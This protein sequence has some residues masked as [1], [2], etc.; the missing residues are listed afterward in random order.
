MTFPNSPGGRN[1]DSEQIDEDPK[2]HQAKPTV[3]HRLLT[4]A[5]RGIGDSISLIG[6]IS[7]YILPSMVIMQIL[8][9]TGIIACI[10]RW[11]YPSMRLFGLPGEASLALFTGYMISP[12]SGLTILVT[13]SPSVRELTILGTML[14]ICH[15]AILEGPIAYRAGV[16]LGTF[17]ASRLVGSLA[18]GFVLNLVLL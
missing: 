4:S 14:A 13:L 18:A 2:L 10:G 9:R 11:M 8:T 6:I 12:I 16:P 3:F 17:M 15:S 1:I 5:C 7:T